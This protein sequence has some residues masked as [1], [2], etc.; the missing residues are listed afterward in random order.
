MSGPFKLAGC[1]FMVAVLAACATTTLRTVE[2]DPA[3]HVSQIHRVLVLNMS[4]DP[5]L[6]NR[7]EDEF[8]R[9]W[10]AR[11]MD[12]VASH[13][14]LAPGIKLEKGPIAAFANAQ[15]FNAVLVTR[16]LGSE[17]IDPQ[18]RGEDFEVP[19][20]SG[21]PGG[22]TDFYKALVASPEYAGNYRMVAV[23]TRIYETA[24]GSRV[25]SATT[26]TLVAEDASKVIKPFV[27]VVLETLYQTP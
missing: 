24:S 7:V 20:S 3:F 10:K 27:K 2:S 4:K 26:Q 22:A 19:L 13:A 16:L 1:A 18:I 8:V 6:R 14:V 5:G 11:G 23:T 25:W 15:K 21:L 17:K 12:A 9:Q